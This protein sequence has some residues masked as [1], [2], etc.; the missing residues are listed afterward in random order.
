[1]T[2]HLALW[3]A[4]SRLRAQLLLRMMQC[5]VFSQQSRTSLALGQVR[6]CNDAHPAGFPRDGGGRFMHGDPKNDSFWGHVRERGSPAAGEAGIN[7]VP[8]EIDAP[9]FTRKLSFSLTASH[10]ASVT[11]IVVQSMTYREALSRTRT[12][13]FMQP[14]IPHV[15]AC[16]Q[17]WSRHPPDAPL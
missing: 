13:V 9:T 14:P 8:S 15:L 2:L 16:C 1:V 12:L 3:L 5:G 4:F 11:N 6:N 7:G 17:P 10:P